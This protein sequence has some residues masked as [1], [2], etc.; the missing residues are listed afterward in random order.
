VPVQESLSMLCEMLDSLRLDMV[1]E[2]QRHE[3]LDVL[4]SIWEIG[5]FK[6][7]PMV[8]HRCKARC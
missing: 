1:L 4:L 5:F 2:N 3:S 8:E 7:T 6:T